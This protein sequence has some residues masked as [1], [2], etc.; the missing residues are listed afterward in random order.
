MNSISFVIESAA[1][2]VLLTA[3]GCGPNI[4]V[5]AC[6]IV[7]YEM[8]LRKANKQLK[9]VQVKKFVNEEEIQKKIAYLK[10]SMFPV[11]GPWLAVR[12]FT[13]ARGD[14]FVDA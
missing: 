3:Y 7:F 12:K 14:G 13:K 6:G 2:C 5:G 8:S 4:V 1:N 11:I 10:L 9:G